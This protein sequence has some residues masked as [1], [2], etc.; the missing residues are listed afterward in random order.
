[1]NQELGNHAILTSK[2]GTEYNLEDSAAPI[3]DDK[4]TVQGV[5]LVFR[6]VTGKKEQREKIEYLSFHD[7]LTGLYNRRFFE[8]EIHRLDTD[9][10]L[11]ISIIMGDVNSLKLT[12]DVFGHTFGDALLEKVSGVLKTACRADDIIARWGG[13]EFVILLPKTG[14]TETKR[15]VDRIRNDFSKE[16][17]KA[18][19]GSIS[20]G[21]A[22]KE[23]ESEDI[24]NVLNVAEER[25]YLAKTLER[26]E[27]KSGAINEIITTLH[28]SNMREKSHSIRVSELCQKLGSRLS[29]AETEILKLKKAGYLHDIGKIVL[30]P[31]LLNMNEQLTSRDNKEIKKHTTV[32][33]R[34][35]GSFDSTMDL[36]E[37]VLAHHEHWDGSGYPKGLKE[38]E[39]PQLS[40]I[41]AVVEHYERMLYDADGQQAMEKQDAIEA[42]IEKAG[43]IYDP[44]VVSTFALMI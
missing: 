28:D 38:N 44:V 12:N 30:D 36:A 8:E 27:V 15:I 40:R 2:D 29:L 26:D 32:G 21:Y 19:K 6:D 42:L 39:I 23:E 11:P 25:M 13:D 4:G 41:I 5:V 9:R 31:R 35:L 16:K 43:T 33:Y 34:I 1:M 37:C 7:S 17:I 3:K 24:A 14:D 20:I 10:N 22:A 18:I